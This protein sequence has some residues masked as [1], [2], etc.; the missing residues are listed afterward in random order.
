MIVEY[1]LALTLKIFGSSYSQAMTALANII[2]KKKICF[3]EQCVLD[4]HLKSGFGNYLFIR[5][6]SMFLVT[7]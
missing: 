6:P 1:A 5:S 7:Y 3:K 2:I 4:Y